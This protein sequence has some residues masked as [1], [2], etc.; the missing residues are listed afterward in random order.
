MNYK[1]INR[2]FALASFIFAM[3]VY[4][5]T[6]QPSVPFWDC[7]EFSSASI[8]QQVP[9]PPGA[10]LFLLLGK[11]FH[12][13]IPF[14]DPGWRLNMLAVVSSALTVFL[15]YLITVKVIENFN[16]KPK[17][18]GSCLATCI[19]GF[20]AAGA[21]TF[22]DTFWFNAVESEVY[23]TS[24]LFVA[25]IT[26]LMMLWNEK[27]DDPRSEKYLLLIFYL[28]GLSSGVHL[29][30]ILTV[31]SVFTI[32]FFR[33]YDRKTTKNYYLKFIAMGILAI[34]TFF[35]IYPFVI[36]NIP[37]FLS[38]HT[39]GRNNFG[40]YSIVDSFGL[41]LF[42]VSIILVAIAGFVYS[43]LK[44]KKILSFITTAFLLI[45]LG[46]TTYTQIL[47]RSNSNTPMNENE[48]K[49]F[50]SLAS[51]LG[52][53]QYGNA[54]TMSRRYQQESRFT[55]NYLKRDEKGDY[56][57]G[58]WTPAEFNYETGEYD[59]D[60]GNRAG[61]LK[62]M[63]DFQMIHMYF[64]YF[65][66]NYI[67]RVSDV[68]DA[69]VAW[70]EMPPD[71]YAWNYNSGYIDE[72][73]IQF[74][75]IP[76]IL[77]LIGLIFHFYRD[78]K[79]A[80]A[81]LFLF[82]LTGILSALSQNQ[83]DPQP[84]ERDYFY[85]ASFVI[86]CLWIGVGI[87]S[88]M[89]M[90]V[91]K[92]RKISVLSAV[93]VGLIAIIA[94]PVNM[95]ASGWKI[96]SRAGNYLPFDYSYN[97]L[98]SCDKDAIVF[99]NGDNDTFPVWY[100]QDVMGVRRDIRIVNLS[101]GN[102]P[103]YIDQ[104]KNRSPWGAKKI[105]LSF[106]DSRLQCDE[107]SDEAIT[108]Y[109]A[110][111]DTLLTIPVRK[112]I[113][114]QYTDDQTIIDRGVMQF[115][116]QGK[117]RQ[118]G[119]QRYYVNHQL[120]RD[121]IEQVKFER[122]VYFSTT[123]GPDVFC[124]LQNNLR[125]EGMMWRVCPIQ[126]KRDEINVDIMHKCLMETDNTNDYHTEPHFGF[127]FR[128]LNNMDVYY[129]EVHRRLMS[130]YRHLYYVYASYMK[131]AKKDKEAAVAILDKMNE[132][133]SPTQF[134]IDYDMIYRLVKIYDDCGADSQRDYLADLGID[135][136]EFFFEHPEVARREIQKEIAGEGAGP[137]RV[138]IML[139]QYKNDYRGAAEVLNR[140]Q[141]LIEQYY[142][143]LGKYVQKGTKE[144]QRKEQ[145]IRYNLIT[146]DME[147][148]IMPLQQTFV[149][150]GVDAA[151][152]AADDLLKFYYDKKTELDSAYARNLNYQIESVKRSDWDIKPEVTDDLTV[153]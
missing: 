46:Y 43:I 80:L 105:P 27:A 18:L 83:Q 95:G 94:V 9:H 92:E 111:T 48:P 58:P 11:M 21:L 35:I 87:F 13:L 19:S 65:G 140:L 113:L 142:H 128:N 97:I 56:V 86:W 137:Y 127:K 40:E 77:G 17:D 102:T 66:W 138:A 32:V 109:E 147:L 146:M 93:I 126:Y 135:R 106:P 28:I 75:A 47:I 89:S 91:N 98:Q 57:Y 6:V 36:K 129:D 117:E 110:R 84:R 141:P 64:R 81:F 108:P 124:G 54:P 73:P 29:L 55:R 118:N 3:A 38:G 23:A 100:L 59:W 88:I 125:L 85:A 74:Y 34:T 133:I 104:L 10:P 30:A 71:H 123:V 70:F 45:I 60:S 130:S 62:Y 103:W 24:A 82:L 151:V 67:G 114:A 107:Y 4:M 5:M 53:E 16:G 79:R 61:D 78:P 50:T 119:V 12:L 22:S 145:S 136:C 144:Y 120:V 14:G 112:E 25:L 15:L 152:K 51:Y 2:L 116:W 96:H 122:T 42:A 153:E 121:I 90:F 132:N 99:T 52:R 101:L 26:Y 37:A 39:P 44:K 33:K 31:F 8:W 41:K 68:Q 63:W 139:H 69:G 72:F 134:P 149:D 150:K 7:S 76:L 131:D 115:R 1:L 20:I 148:E 143:S 49:D